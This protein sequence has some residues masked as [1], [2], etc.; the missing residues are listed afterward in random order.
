MAGA[1]IKDIAQKAGISTATVDRVL[2]RR[3]GVSAA[4]R[5]RVLKAANK[6][7]YLPTDGMFIMPSRPAHLEFFLPSS[8]SSFLT[9]LGDAILQFAET[10]PLVASCRV[11]ALEGLGSTA[12]S[13]ALD[14]ID[15]RTNGVGLV[16]VDNAAT[17]EIVGRLCDAN[18]RVVTMAS[19]VLSAPAPDY[20]GVD[21]RAA[22]RTAGHMMGLIAADRP[23][24]VALFSGLKA[25]HG[26]R[27]REEGFRAA[28]GELFPHLTLLPAEETG[29]D[30]R[31]SRR[32]LARI[33]REQGSLV[34][35]YCIGGGRTGIVEALR[36][37][38]R[39]RPLVILHE[40]AGGA[41]DWLSDGI[42]DLIIDQNVDALAEQSVI[43][44]L[45]S[46]AAGTSLLQ[47][48]NIDMRLV[49]RENIPPVPA[50]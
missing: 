1:T 26:H 37:L 43:R 33:L 42:V 46:I 50:R 21:N 32:A 5:Q 8:R 47:N 44:L 24:H 28:L 29:E 15:I 9:D 41:R 13:T 16:A 31:Q 10:L 36:D 20:V 11:T 38:G 30:S 35:V 3:S 19:N 25:F 22:G 2:N 6:L 34:G 48:R 39:E 4:T 40:L 23:G 18:V 45:G 14:T 7:G 49:V 17:R 12:L 27:E